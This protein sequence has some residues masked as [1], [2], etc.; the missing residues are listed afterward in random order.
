MLPL[1]SLLTAQDNRNTEKYSDIPP[2]GIRTHFG[3][4]RVAED[5]RGLRRRVLLS[6]AD[7]VTIYNSFRGVRMSCGLLLSM[8]D[9]WWLNGQ[10]HSY[11]QNLE[12]IKKQWKRYNK[13]KFCSSPHPEHIHGGRDVAVLTSTSALFRFTHG[14]EHWYPLNRRLGG[15]R[16]DLN[17]VWRG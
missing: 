16:A 17:C 3:S 6:A 13:V 10:T 4:F 11:M 12:P 2:G 15:P 8:S 9:D 14:K 5:S 7:A 1:V